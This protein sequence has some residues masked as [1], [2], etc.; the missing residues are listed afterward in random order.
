MMLR[1]R[2]IASIVKIC[3]GA[4]EASNAPALLQI[5]APKA[6]SVEASFS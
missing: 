6:K 1:V 4:M 3:D 5:D 2:R